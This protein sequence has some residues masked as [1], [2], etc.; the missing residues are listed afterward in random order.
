MKYPKG[1]LSTKHQSRVFT[2]NGLNSFFTK[3][4]LDLFFTKN[5]LRIKKIFLNKKTQRTSLQQCVKGM[6]LQE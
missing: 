6:I 3:N 4:D 5:N 2:N 1:K